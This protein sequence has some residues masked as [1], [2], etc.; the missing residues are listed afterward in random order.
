MASHE[1]DKVELPPNHVM[2]D[3]NWVHERSRWKCKIN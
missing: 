1:S 3:A 2:K